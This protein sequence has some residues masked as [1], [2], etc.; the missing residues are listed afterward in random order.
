[1]RAL[2]RR[3]EMEYPSGA[4]AKMIAHVPPIYLEARNKA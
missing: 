4:G 2:L 1:V 3:F